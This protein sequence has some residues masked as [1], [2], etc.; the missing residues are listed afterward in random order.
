MSFA[1]QSLLDALSYVRA[2][3]GLPGKSLG[4]VGD[5]N[6]LDGYHLGR[7]RIFGPD[8]VGDNDYSVRTTRDRAGLTDAASALDIGEWSRSALRALTAWLLAEA[9]ADRLSDVRELIGPADDGRAYKWSHRDGWRPRRRAKGD[10][11]ETHLHISYYRDSEGRSK[12][13]PFRQFFEPD[14]EGVSVADV[15]T[16]FHEL[17]DEAARRSTPTGRQVGDDIATLLGK[18]TTPLRAEVSD[19][20]GQVAV[21]TALVQQLLARPPVTGA[22]DQGRQ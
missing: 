5:E 3:T 20:R 17:F 7:D 14:E 16:G 15:R 1:P 8:G 10:S 4:V 11:H 22:D 21:F 2:R 18:A 13:E 19:L 12:V 9:R 6:H